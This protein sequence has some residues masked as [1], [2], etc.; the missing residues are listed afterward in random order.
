MGKHLTFTVTSH[1]FIL[2]F[3]V[4]NSLRNAVHTFYKAIFIYINNT[5]IQAR[6][7]RSKNKKKIRKIKQQAFILTLALFFF[8]NFKIL[9]D[10]KKNIFVY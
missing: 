3:S 9:K 4:A 8:Q 10:L 5:T 6:L 1:K 7:R 2:F